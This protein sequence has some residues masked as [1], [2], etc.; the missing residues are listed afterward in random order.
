MYAMRC[1][2]ALLQELEFKCYELNSAICE[3]S[4]AYTWVGG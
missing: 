4:K 2:F 1:H 3:V